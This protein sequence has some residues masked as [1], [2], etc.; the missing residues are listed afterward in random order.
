VRV[1]SGTK[2]RFENKDAAQ[3]VVFHITGGLTGLAHQADPGTPPGGVYEQTL[4][5]TSGQTDWYCH[6]RNNPGNMLL[7]A[8]P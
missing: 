7:Q 3:N 1:L 2:L 4:T 6:N 5:A 8:Q